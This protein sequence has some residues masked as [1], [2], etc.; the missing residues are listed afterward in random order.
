[1]IRRHAEPLTQL[2]D[3]TAGFLLRLGRP[4]GCSSRSSVVG[5]LGEP[6]WC[7]PVSGGKVMRGGTTIPS[8]RWGGWPPWRKVRTPLLNE[9]EKGREAEYRHDLGGCKPNRP[10]PVSRAL[11]VW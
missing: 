11:M 10:E 9:A 1:M 7:F 8:H 5:T 6:P 2:A 4:E 3:G